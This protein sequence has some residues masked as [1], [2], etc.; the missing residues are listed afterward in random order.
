MYLYS[1]FSIIYVT[2][3]KRRRH[4]KETSSKKSPKTKDKK[5]SL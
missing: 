3:Q 4:S 2:E 1:Q 5:K